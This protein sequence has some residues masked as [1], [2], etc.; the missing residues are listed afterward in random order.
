MNFS[1]R[2]S[3]EKQT[4][5]TLWNTKLLLL[6][7]HLLNVI[8]SSKLFIRKKQAKYLNVLLSSIMVSFKHGWKY[9]YSPKGISL[10]YFGVV[11][12]LQR[13]LFISTSVS[14]ADR[15][16]FCECS[17]GQA[18]ILRRLYKVP[19]LLF[20]EIRAVLIIFVVVCILEW[21]LCAYI[22]M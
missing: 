4:E 21:F 16:C 1:V 14:K 13:L 17:W 12:V 18:L 6:K 9:W 8:W 7:V 20:Y 15:H 22:H 5:K 11:L 19:V 2:L 10:P 3:L